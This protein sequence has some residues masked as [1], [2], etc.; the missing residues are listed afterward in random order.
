MLTRRDP[1]KRHIWKVEDPGN[2]ELAPDKNPSYL[3]RHEES[4]DEGGVVVKKL[5]NTSWKKFSNWNNI[6]KESFFDELQKYSFFT[7]NR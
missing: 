1:L 3:S 6:P 2:K 5:C 7:Q 4:R